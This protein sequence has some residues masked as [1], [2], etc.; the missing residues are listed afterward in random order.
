M[1]M[2][3]SLQQSISLLSVVSLSILPL[4]LQGSFGVAVRNSR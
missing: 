3:F 2:M 1:T 4:I